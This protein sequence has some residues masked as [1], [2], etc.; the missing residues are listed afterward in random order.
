[1]ETLFQLAE[2]AATDIQYFTQTI[3]QELKSRTVKIPKGI[4]GKL[5]ALDK[6]LTGDTFWGRFARYVLHTTG[7]EDYEVKDDTVKQLR[8]P[9]QRVQKLAAQVATDTAL[10]AMHLPQFVSLMVTA[11]TS[12]VPSSQK[13]FL[14]RRQSKQ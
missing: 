1:M 4:R 5:R 9:S 6:K 11:C 10:F 14:R 2:D 8:Q 12:S 3:I 7:D 13:C